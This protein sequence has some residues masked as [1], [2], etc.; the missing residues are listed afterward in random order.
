M[1][2]P[3]DVDEAPDDSKLPG[4]VEQYDDA[5]APVTPIQPVI[6]P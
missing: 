5:P 2:E 6:E 4:V 1:L 3:P